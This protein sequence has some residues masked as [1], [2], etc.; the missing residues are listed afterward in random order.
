MAHHKS[1]LKRIR[2][3]RRRRLY[4]RSNKKLAKEAIKAV[5]SSKS[6]DEAVEKLSK[7]YKILDK[8]SAKRVLHKNNAANRKSQLAR[9]VNSLRTTEK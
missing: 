1:A 7:A 6:Y 8:I 3:N 2:Q 9:F 5:K 4:N